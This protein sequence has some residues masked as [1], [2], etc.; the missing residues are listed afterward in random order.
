MGDTDT[1]VDKQSYPS[2][3]VSQLFNSI[4]WG[5]RVSK[6]RSSTH[7]IQPHTWDTHSYSMRY[8]Q[9]KIEEGQIDLSNPFHVEESNSI[10]GRLEKKKKVIYNLYSLS[11]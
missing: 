9:Y 1:T 2:D 6:P 5:S 8:L 3:H 10:R 11:L 4:D 7:W